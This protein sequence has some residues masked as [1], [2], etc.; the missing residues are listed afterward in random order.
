MLSD[1]GYRGA[2]RTCYETAGITSLDL[3][4][5]RHAFATRFLQGGG[6]VLTLARLM[7]TSVTMIDRTYGH[8]TMDHARR[9]LRKMG[10]IRQDD[11]EKTRKD[12]VSEGK[13]MYSQVS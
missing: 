9:V 6:D 13:A 3:I 7:G 10:Q 8:L 1:A 2:L 12:G 5:F 11:A 4:G